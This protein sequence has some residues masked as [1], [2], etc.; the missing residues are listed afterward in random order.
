MDLRAYQ[1]AVLRG[2]H[3]KD[4]AGRIPHAALGLTG[5]A[6]E[7]AD[8]IK[9]SQYT[10]GTLDIPHLIEE[11]GDTLWYL[12]FLAGVLGYP[13][14]ELASLNIEKL[15]KRNPAAY[16]GVR[17]RPENPCAEGTCTCPAGYCG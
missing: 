12:T 14:D 4:D 13:L 17:T 2:M 9:K 3:I 16:G 1:L 11:L 10:N 15:K 8:I 6:G 7:V 5:E